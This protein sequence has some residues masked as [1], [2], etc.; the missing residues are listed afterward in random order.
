MESSGSRNDTVLGS[1]PPYSVQD[2]SPKHSLP[3]DSRL[4]ILTATCSLPLPSK[5]NGMHLELC[6]QRA[7]LGRRVTETLC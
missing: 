5:A 3:V 6:T 7:G 2:P 1:V 4:S